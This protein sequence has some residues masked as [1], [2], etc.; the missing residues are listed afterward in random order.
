MSADKK[1]KIELEKRYGRMQLTDMVNVM[2][3]DEYLR[4]N[5]KRCP[6]C[7]APIQK[8]EGCNK[9]SCIK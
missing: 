6:N 9:M 7:R 8:T 3:D 1:K 5:A 4:E 2:L